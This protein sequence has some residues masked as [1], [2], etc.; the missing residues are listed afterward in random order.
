VI[1][2]RHTFQVTHYEPLI[3]NQLILLPATSSAIEADPLDDSS[4]IRCHTRDESGDEEHIVEDRVGRVTFKYRSTGNG[5]LGEGGVGFH[6]DG[7]CSHNAT[8]VGA[9]GV[10]VYDQVFR[11]AEAGVGGLSGGDEANGAEHAA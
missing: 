5:D 4:L 3:L 9:R 2:P 11:G 8:I 1:L 7:Y 10:E 6:G